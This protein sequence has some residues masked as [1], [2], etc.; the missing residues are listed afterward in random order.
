MR[1]RLERDKRKA[2][3]WNITRRTGGMI[4]LEFIAQLGQLAQGRQLSPSTPVALEQ[5][6]NA[7]WLHENDAETLIGAH[8]LYSDL[9]QLL[10]AAHGE[11][12]NPD[13]V[14]KPLARRLSYRAG[15]EDLDC[16]IKRLQHTADRVRQ[17]FLRYVG[18]VQFPVIE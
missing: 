12:F 17:L 14:S 9:T 15:C 7:G 1:A 11:R 6:M 4:D 3:P 2:S 8:R 16:V 18:P 5:L 10:K 13:S